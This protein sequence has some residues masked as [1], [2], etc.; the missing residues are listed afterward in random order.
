MHGRIVRIA[1]VESS[2]MVDY[3][4]DAVLEPTYIQS[5]Y[6]FLCAS[7]SDLAATPPWAC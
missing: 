3:G 4:T 6:A 7:F 1:I 2:V 5:N